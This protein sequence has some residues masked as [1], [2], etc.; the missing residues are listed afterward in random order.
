MTKEKNSFDP[1]GTNAEILRFF[2]QQWNQIFDWL[3]AEPTDSFLMRVLKA[4]GKVLAVIAFVLL[5][6][7]VAVTLFIAFLIAF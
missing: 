5:S 2:K 3:K 7:V 6:P 1:I 4:L